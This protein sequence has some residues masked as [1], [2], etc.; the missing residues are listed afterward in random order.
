MQQFFQTGGYSNKL[1]RISRRAAKQNDKRT[2]EFTLHQIISIVYTTQSIV[3]SCSQYPNF[4][5]T[6]HVR[7]SSCT[8]GINTFRANDQKH[9]PKQ[10]RPTPAPNH[11]LRRMGSSDIRPCTAW[12]PYSHSRAFT[13]GGRPKV[14]R[15]T[16]EILARPRPYEEYLL[17]PPPPPARVTLLKFIRITP[18]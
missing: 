15:R 18:V 12:C 14:D 16:I 1:C 9:R 10:S 4:I 17:L 8:I 2:R 3:S 13:E 11:S 5:V 6:L 7:R